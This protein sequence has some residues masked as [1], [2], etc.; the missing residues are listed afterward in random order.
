MVS[1]GG[2]LV[3][4]PAREPLPRRLPGDAEL[5][6]DGGGANP[7]V[8]HLADCGRIE[9]RLAASVDAYANESRPTIESG[10]LESLRKLLAANISIEFHKNK[11]SEV[12]EFMTDIHELNVSIDITVKDLLT[13]A[14]ISHLGLSLPPESEA[15]NDEAA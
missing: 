1:R 12:M 7:L 14:L 5:L 13:E 9:L 15:N 2:S 3:A 11:L 4:R 10:A 8:L 6:A